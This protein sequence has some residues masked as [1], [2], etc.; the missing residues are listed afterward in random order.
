MV[1]GFFPMVA[2]L[3]HVGHLS[4][5]KEA[6][7]NCDYLIVGLNCN[8]ENKNPVQTISERYLQLN[9]IK[10]VDE[11]IPYSGKKDLENLI[12]VLNY[13]IRFLGSDHIKDNWDGKEQEK[14]A[15]HRVFYLHRLH[16]FSSTD[17]KNRIIN[18]E[19]KKNV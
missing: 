19:E 7:E 1:K 17:L 15:N 4:A 5:I 3:L 11:I 6:K 13:D 10:D 18:N 16:N 2:D 12:F 9:A 8:P 14:K